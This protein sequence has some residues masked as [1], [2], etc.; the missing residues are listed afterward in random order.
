MCAFSTITVFI[1]IFLGARSIF[2]RIIYICLPLAVETNKYLVIDCLGFMAVD[3]IKK[4]LFG[5]DSVKYTDLQALISALTLSV[6]AE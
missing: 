5:V 6:W 4:H 3:I 2:Q 1:Y